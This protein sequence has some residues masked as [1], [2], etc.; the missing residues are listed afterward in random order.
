MPPVDFTDEEHAALT[1][2]VRRELAETKYPHSDDSR[3][4]RE[5]LAKLDPASVRKPLFD[6]MPLPK[7]PM[8][9]RG[10]RRARR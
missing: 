4:P 3:T 8:R 10:G 9:A 2:L 7:A 1:A 6:R 5:A